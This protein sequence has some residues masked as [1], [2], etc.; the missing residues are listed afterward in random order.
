MI[1]VV[2]LP[3]ICFERIVACPHL[4]EWR[5]ELGPFR[6]VQHIRYVLALV[7]AGRE[8]GLESGIER[9][10]QVKEDCHH[11]QHGPNKRDVRA[12]E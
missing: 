7:E 12:G 9:S 3:V 1:Q 6:H 8:W 11:R 10:A 5:K 2:W 4:R